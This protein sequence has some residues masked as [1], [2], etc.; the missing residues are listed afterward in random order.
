VNGTLSKPC[1]LLMWTR[2][3]RASSTA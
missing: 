1:T 3:H 2:R